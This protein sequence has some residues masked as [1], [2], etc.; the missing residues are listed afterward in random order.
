VIVEEVET[1][2]GK[3]VHAILQ[4]RP[5]HTREEESNLPVDF[6]EI[7]QAFKEHIN[8]DISSRPTINQSRQ[9]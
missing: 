1:S 6:N 4:T 3:I 7:P 9:P 2:D 5:K 8:Y